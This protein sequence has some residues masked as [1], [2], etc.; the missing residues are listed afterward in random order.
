MNRPQNRT[1]DGFLKKFSYLA[2]AH[3]TEIN[4]GLLAGTAELPLST[5][6]IA[7]QSRG[8]VWEY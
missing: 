7:S 3:R 5:V 1:M 8:R 4:N 2:V 6:V